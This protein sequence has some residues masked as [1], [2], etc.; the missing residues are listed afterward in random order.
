MIRR[1]WIELVILILFIL[2]FI[3]NIMRFIG[4]GRRYYTKSNRI[5]GLVVVITGANSGIGKETALEL[6]KR[7]ARVVMACR[8]LERGLKAA[9][10]I[11]DLLPNAML[12]VMELDLSSFESINRFAYRL[13]KQ[14]SIVDI[15]I[16]NAGIMACPLK[17]SVH[18]HELQFATNHLGH[19]LLTKQ[20]LPLLATSSNPRVVTLSTIHHKRGRIFQDYDFRSQSYDPIE[21][22]CQSKLANVLFR[23]NYQDE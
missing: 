9:K 19:F 10:Q 22:Y 20:L 17:R 12:D 5:D 23:Q 7:G 4:L 18:N 8:N 16:N 14:H 2:E 1:V 13:K 3:T 6:S 21:A 15:L 11:Q